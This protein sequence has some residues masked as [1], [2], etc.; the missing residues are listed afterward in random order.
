MTSRPADQPTQLMP[1]DIEREGEARYLE[2]VNS[3]I[4]TPA[5]ANI[6][7]TSKLECVIVEP[8]KHAALKGVLHNF[9]YYLPNACFTLYHSME[10]QELANELRAIAPNL[11]T[12]CF[13]EGNMAREDYSALLESL[14]FWNDRRGER[15]LI[16]QT[17]TGLRK[18]D[19]AKFWRYGYVGAPWTW[20]P[21]PADPFFLVGNGGLSLRDPQLMRDI[22]IRNPPTQ[23][24]GHNEDLYFANAALHAGR[25]P[26]VETAAEFSV[27]WMH[28]PDPMGFHQAYRFE[29]YPDAYRRSLVPPLRHTPLPS[30]TL[31]SIESAHIEDAHFRI[32]VHS[33]K[34]VPLM[35]SIVGPD[36]LRL[37]AGT[38]MW[39]SV[40]QYA[41]HPG[42]YDPKT[43]V[44]IWLH[45]DGKERQ[46]TCKLDQN[47]RI[48][49]DLHIGAAST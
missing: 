44:V 21:Y 25:C 39:G 23:G 35:R 15:V 47:M 6:P 38:S 22:L 46:T 49:T 14:A 26:D 42:M 28:H 4:G 36:G 1:T 31:A 27:E 45:K 18:N 33:R 3:F 41:L 40:E 7:S 43:L 30:C 34:L 5:F 17:D 2:F 9:A 20:T 24:D 32:L 29:I 19:I 12:V 13:R 48:A 16:F 11:H 10:N 8:R 37:G